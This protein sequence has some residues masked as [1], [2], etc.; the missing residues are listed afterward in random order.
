MDAAYWRTGEDHRVLTR[1]IAEVFIRSRWQRF[2]VHI[3]RNVLAV[4][5]KGHSQVVNVFIR[6]S[7]AQPASARVDE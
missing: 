2:R 3:M 7:F 1:A 5:P 4:V 6:T